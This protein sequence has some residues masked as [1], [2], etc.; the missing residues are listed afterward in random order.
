MTLPHRRCGDLARREQVENE[1]EDETHPNVDDGSRV[2]HGGV[3][4]GVEEGVQLAGGHCGDGS[5]G[6]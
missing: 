5:G 3:V 2:R 6:S 4:G 1:M